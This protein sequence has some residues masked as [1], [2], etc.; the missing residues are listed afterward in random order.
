MRTVLILHLFI[1]VSWA[2]YG[3]NDAFQSLGTTTRMANLGQA[4]SAD[5]GHIGAWIM[6]PAAVAGINGRNYYATY[7]H[8]FGMAEYLSGGFTMSHDSDWQWGVFGIGVYVDNIFLRPDLR[9]ISDLETRRDSV[10]ALVARGFNTFNDW[11]L[12]LSFNLTRR[13]Q[14]TLDLG[15]MLDDIPLEIPVGL[16][17]HLIRKQLYRIEGMGIGGDLGGMI[18]LNLHDL[19][20]VDNLGQLAFGLTVKHPAGTRIQWNT[21]RQDLIPQQTVTGFRYTQSKLLNTLAVSL[22]KQY[23]W[24]YREQNYGLEIKAGRFLSL[25]VGSR[26]GYYQGGLEIDLDKFGFSGSL[27]YGFSN[28]EFGMI[29]RFGLQW[30]Q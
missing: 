14:W 8:Q 11:E 18:I 15:W 10:R 22:Y 23:N 30:H 2:Q 20:P 4:V 17:V 5:Y 9:S 28:H 27:G 13:N 7:I 1:T 6:N 25:D 26:D 21:G 12:S 29:H 16:N 3:Y 24:R 19:V